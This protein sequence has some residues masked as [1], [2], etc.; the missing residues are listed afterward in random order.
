MKKTSLLLFVSFLLLFV[1]SQTTYAQSIPQNPNQVENGKRQGRW[2][3][4]LNEKKSKVD[5]IKK[6][7]YYRILTYQD[8]KPTGI[9]QDYYLNGKLQMQGKLIAEGLAPKYE[10]TVTYFRPNG[11]KDYEQKY[12]NGKLISKVYFN[13]NGSV[14]KEDWEKLIKNAMDSFFLQGKYEQALSLVQ[15][16]KQLASKQFGDKHP[17]YAICL[18]NEA[19][20]YITQGKNYPKA[21]KSLHKAMQITQ[22][23]LGKDHEDYLT[24]LVQVGN[25]YYNKGLLR[26]A[27][28]LFR[29]AL[30]ISKV[31]YKNE[32][33]T[34]Y[35]LPLNNLAA[36]SLQ[37]GKYAQADTLFT[38]ASQIFEK[39]NTTAYA[40]SLN[41]L[42]N[43][44]YYQTKYKKADSVA[45]L[46]LQIQE[47]ENR[48]TPYYAHTLSNLATSYLKQAKYKQADSLFIQIK[49]VFEKT[50]KDNNFYVSYL[51]N[52]ASTYI[53]KAQY[54]QAAPIYVE[55]LESQAK[56]IGER[57]P[58][59]ATVLSNLGY[60][61]VNQGKYA[62]AE[63]KLLVALDIFEKGNL[64]SHTSYANV[65]LNL[66]E[67]Y[68]L[69]GKYK[70]A[71]SYFLKAEALGEAHPDYAAILNNLANFYS[72]TGEFAKEEPLRPQIMEI[73]KKNIGEKH[74]DYATYLDN[75]ATFYENKGEY[76]KT[77]SLYQ[78]GLKITKDNL[79]ENHPDYA[80]RLGNWG[81]YYFNQSTYSKA[82][83][84]FLKAIQIFKDTQSEASPYYTTSLQNLANVYANQGEYEKAESLLL[85][86]LE[87]RKDGLGKN[88]DSYAIT[89]SHLGNLYKTQMNYAEAIPLY[90]E[91]IPIF[92][93]TTGG[94]NTYYANNLSA[95]AD[96]Y[97]SLKQYAKA[98]SLYLQV[99]NL[100]K[101]VYGE[102]HPE[103]GVSLG[104]WASSFRLQKKY[105]RAEEL[106]LKALR[107]IGKA[108]GENH[109][110]YA[111]YANQLAIVYD[112]QNKFEQATSLYLKMT[113]SKV[114]EIQN[115]LTNLSESGKQ[116]YLKE[117]Q[118]V[119]SNLHGY[120]AHL[121]EKQPTHRDLPKLLQAAF[122]LQLRTK[123]LLLSE[124]Q[125]V[126]NRIFASSD[127]A[128]IRQMELWQAKK[129]IVAKAYN[130]TATERK[131][132]NLDPQKLETEA[133]DLEKVLVTRSADF[134]PA[135]SS[136]TYTYQDIQKKMG[137]NDIAIE[138]IKGERIN[139]ENPKQDTTFYYL[140]LILT[141]KEL[142][143]VLMDNGREMD[144]DAFHYYRASVGR[145]TDEASYGEF[146][147]KI[148]QNLP[149][150]PPKGERTISPFE[151]GQGD[152]AAKIYFSPDGVYNQ[153]NLNTLF[154]PQ[155][156]KYLLEEYDIH[157]VTNLKE[158]AEE[159]KSSTQKTASL[160]GRP[161]YGMS[162][163]DYD[164][165]TIGLRGKTDIA[166]PN[167]ATQIA[168][169][170]LE[171][172]QIEVV[173]IDSVLR[174]N[175]WKTEIFL[176][177]EAVEERLKKVKDPTILHVATH[178]YFAPTNSKTKVNNMLS[179]GI[180]LAG[181]NT[182]GKG[183][184]SE[185][186]I[187]TALEAT[188]LDL[189]QTDLV[190]LS[191]CET[192]LGE[193]AVGEG[194]YGL[195]RGF[196]VAGAK[197][198]LMSLWSVDDGATQDLMNTF[199]NLWLEGMPKRVAF[200]QA[201]MAI[202]EKYAKPYYWG[203]FVMIG[204]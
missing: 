24:A 144:A 199:Y 100:Y 64:Q 96:T 87:I 179:S 49:E 195:Q 102:K 127:S 116:K 120:I 54:A 104:N 72:Y 105:E 138:M 46:S 53:Y 181:V 77:D 136:P 189:D 68:R 22:K 93:N 26:E 15:K 118:Y 29:E 42:T 63:E 41:N 30:Q 10:G 129:N 193:V 35:A 180:V 166:T 82:E 51:I 84:L 131:K 169:K 186:G 156:G 154:N 37:L 117:N 11:K 142:I 174:K 158:I 165:N 176:D 124:T 153:I 71:K 97:V 204:D 162:K 112:D 202:K 122:N 187:L 55:A 185:D 48:I 128:L 160:F 182:V 67:L 164:Q 86:V 91:A 133:D 173:G 123:G 39:I 107:I 190:V 52:L 27:E 14:V 61:Y 34:N 89:L 85:Q 188:N 33:P 92:K 75:L 44:Y 19:G 62:Q 98:D 57:H 103:Y 198:V 139:W 161:A 150:P 38:E 17:N 99:V 135:F 109:P 36:I 94:K 197:A 125:K 3:I 137:E 171:S 170:D 111:I 167:I 101:E 114:E 148:A 32:S 183:K 130:M 6:A 178:G 4:L 66:G 23:A 21:Q 145:E 81:G 45:L 56:T 47:K 83:P 1:S 95:L 155:T 106:L 9:T 201:Q 184:N 31:K 149:L 163:Q 69:Q 168:W 146:W 43:V 8:G 25:I 157:V 200:K 13:L 50:G 5:S 73:A 141:K 80:F 151:G 78:L 59:Y 140:A 147:K 121:L 126:K 196:K 28:P 159:K 20:I 192:G 18:T 152:V 90:E 74:P 194:V 16:G 108:K 110:T 70:Q 2:T 113:A 143:P 7:T 134:Q 58:D 60:V 203:G 12:E 76:S 175:G 191:A 132:R 172:T 40:I 115:N 65:L 177:K 88:S 119:F 79:G